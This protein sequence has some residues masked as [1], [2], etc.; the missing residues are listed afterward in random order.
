MG[1]LANTLDGKRNQ[2]M[3]TPAVKNAGRTRVR[4]VEFLPN[5]SHKDH[6]KRIEVIRLNTKIAYILYRLSKNCMPTKPKERIKEAIKNFLR[7]VT[8]GYPEHPDWKIRFE[9]R[10]GHLINQ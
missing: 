2:K 6:K 7:L 1:S 8:A 10:R 9:R 4:R 5:P 3:P